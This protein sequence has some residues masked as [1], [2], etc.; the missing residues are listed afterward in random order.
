MTQA[1]LYTSI[2]LGGGFF[3][4][5]FWAASPLAA[6]AVV[7]IAAGWVLLLLRGYARVS[8]FGLLAAM[9]AAG[10]GALVELNVG[11]LLGGALAALAAWDLAHFSRRLA[12]AAPGDPKDRV[13]ILHLANLGL[14][15]VVGGGLALAAS[16]VEINL[17]IAPA[18]ALALFAGVGA[19]AFIHWLRRG[20]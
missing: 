10:A 18:F 6:L 4:L 14:V 13:E 1:L 5:A 9:L 15:L 16:V 20:K 19:V 3:A 11:L 17:G 2:A 7:F 8:Y 12:R